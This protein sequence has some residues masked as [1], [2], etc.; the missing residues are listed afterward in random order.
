MRKFNV[1]WWV[2][3]EFLG[4]REDHNTDTFLLL[5]E[6]NGLHFEQPPF[7]EPDPALR[8]PKTSIVFNYTARK[9]ELRHRMNEASEYAINAA[10][11]F[12]AAQAAFGRYITSMPYYEFWR[13][14]DL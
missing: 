13:P 9:N 3:P 6:N 12:H 4:R 10:K 14:E 11:E 1:R 5:L 8:G 2:D 7:T